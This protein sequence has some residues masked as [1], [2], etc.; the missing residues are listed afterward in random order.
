LR[1]RLIK[2]HRTHVSA[3]LAC[4]KHEAKLLVGGNAEAVMDF[5]L[6]AESKAATP[7]LSSVFRSGV[8]LSRS[9]FAV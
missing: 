5:R 4:K 3:S 7:R 9:G 6:I 8:Q 2:E 1:T